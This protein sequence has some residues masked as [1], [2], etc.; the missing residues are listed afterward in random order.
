[1]CLIGGGPVGAVRS[2]KNVGF[3]GLWRVPCG[4]LVGPCGIFAEVL[5]CPEG[6]WKEMGPQSRGKESATAQQES[7][8]E[9]TR[10]PQEN[11]HPQK[12]PQEKDKHDIVRTNA[13]VKPRSLV[14]STAHVLSW[15]ARC[16]SK[17]QLRQR[18]FD[19]TDQDKANT[20]PI[21]ARS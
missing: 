6:I 3:C 17:R 12:Y 10:N 11:C 15:P 20:F 5:G 1:M 14:G 4:V 9:T 2:C 8:K 7:H 18:M 13:S 21:S 16:P 19:S